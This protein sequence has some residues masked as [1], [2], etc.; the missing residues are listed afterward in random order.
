MSRFPANRVKRI[1]RR[2]EY[3]FIWS[4][5]HDP[6]WIM[7]HILMIPINLVRES[8]TEGMAVAVGAFT[9]ALSRLSEALS[10]RIVAKQNA[11][12]SDREIIASVS[13]YR[14]SV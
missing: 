13:K 6:F 8:R 9:M 2:N 4:N 7:S 1:V 5:V 14:N 12:R 3:L 11:V 10:A